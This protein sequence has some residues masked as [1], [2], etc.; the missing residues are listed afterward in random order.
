MR[1]AYITAYTPYGRG[2]T[3]VLDEMLMMAELGV[4]LVIVPRNPPREVFHKEAQ[5]LLNQTIWL[6]LLDG[7]ILFRFLQAIS[8][9]PRLWRVLWNVIINSRPLKILVKNLAVIPKA[10]FVAVLFKQR[11]VEHIHAH[12]GS[13]TAT[14]AWVISEL[15]GIPWSF[16]L[17]RWDIAENN[18]LKLKVERAVFARCISQA[19]RDEVLQIIGEEY[20]DKIKVLHLGV[21]VPERLPSEAHKP[22]QEFVIVCPANFVIQKGHRF[23][24]E[25]CKLLVDKEITNFQC[26]L[27]GDGPLEREIREQIAQ[28]KL[29]GIIHLTGRLPHDALMQMYKN[30][31]VD[32]VVLPSIVTDDGEKEGI[33]VSL[34]EAMAY[35]MPVISTD[36]GAIP[37]LLCEGA[38]ILVSPGSAEALA[39]SIQE[40]IGDRSTRERLA[41]KGRERVKA[42]FNLEKNVQRLINMMKA[43]AAQ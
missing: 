19:G 11:G 3:F 28:Y 20:S 33:P 8:L 4:D 39:Q 10:V 26:L 7:L 25:A 24:V 40:L 32:A 36:T 14:M 18:M 41:R 31:E 34:M 37:E 6:P 15:T 42:D 17:H 27:I 2:E 21:R 1:I 5:K 29:D 43:C 38:G 35:G 16:T 13:T 9:R 23:L 12:W 22:R 30:G